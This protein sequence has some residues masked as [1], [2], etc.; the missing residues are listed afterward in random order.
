MRLVDAVV[1]DLMSQMIRPRRIGIHP[2]PPPHGLEPAK[3]LDV[4]QRHTDLLIDFP[5]QAKLSTARF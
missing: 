5:A 4:L 3:D 2:R 1:D